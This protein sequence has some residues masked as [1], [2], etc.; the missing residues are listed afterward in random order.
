LDVKHCWG[1]GDFGQCPLGDKHENGKE[2]ELEHVRETKV[3][4]GIKE[5]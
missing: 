4:A 3:C 1:K 5:N 2:R